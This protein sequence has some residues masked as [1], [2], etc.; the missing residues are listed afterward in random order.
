MIISTVMTKDTNKTKK[1][2]KFWPDSRVLNL[3]ILNYFKNSYFSTF[4]QNFTQTAK[5][6]GHNQTWHHFLSEN[7]K[8]F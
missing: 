1:R 5:L 4:C 8:V 7:V 3:K 2:D 6:K